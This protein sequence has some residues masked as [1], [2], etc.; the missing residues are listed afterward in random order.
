[1]PPNNHRDRHVSEML[2][3][4]YMI[5]SK[6]LQCLLCFW[7]HPLKST[8]VFQCILPTLWDQCIL[9][10]FAQSVNT[11]DGTASITTAAR[12]SPAEEHSLSYSPLLPSSRTAHV[13]P[14]AHRILASL[15]ANLLC[16]SISFFFQPVLGWLV[17]E[18]SVHKCHWSKP[19]LRSILRHFN[20]L[21]A[22]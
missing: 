17:I 14:G 15:P 7:K 19:Q 2:V 1:M 6:T 11:S 13:Q 5:F 3:I 10:S 8:Y 16:T 4:C 9:H 22:C 20:T 18:L 12:V 21:S